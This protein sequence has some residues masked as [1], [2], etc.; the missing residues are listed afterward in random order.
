[1]TP[2]ELALSDF[3]YF[4]SRYPLALNQWA[5][6]Q[7]WADKIQAAY[8]NP[9]IE[10]ILILAPADHGKTSRLSIP[11][12]L[13]LLAR[14]PSHRIIVASGRDE[15]AEQIA[16]AAARHIENNI[17][18]QEDFDLR[19]SRAKWTDAM[20][21]VQRPN[22][23]DKDASILSVGTNSEIQSQRGDTLLCD[24]ICTKKNSKTPDMRAELKS[25][26]NTDLTSRL[27]MPGGKI[28]VLGHRVHKYDLYSEL[29]TRDNWIVIED[30]AIVSD[31]EQKVLAP[32][33]WTYPKLC[34]RRT[35]DPVGFALFYQQ[36]PVDDGI[37]VTRRNCEEIRD[38]SRPLYHQIPEE[39]R[40]K[41][42]K[43]V[44]AVDPAFSVNRWSKY[45][46][47]SVWGYYRNA[48]N[49]VARDLLY[50]FRDRTS[51]EQLEQILTAKIL[52]TQ[53][54]IIAYEKN[55]GQVLLGPMIRRALPQYASR[56][57]GAF[58]ESK[59]GSL[60]VELGKLFETVRKGPSYI[61]VP[62]GNEDARH[63]SEAFF[64]E[65]TNYPGHPFTD[66]I[67]SWYIAEKQ[68]GAL[69]ADERKGY[70]KGQGVVRDVS[71]AVRRGQR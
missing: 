18:L 26:F 4:A 57:E 53:P 19:P 45:T 3:A 2:K 62:Y 66:S 38:M 32:E 11:L 46:V 5:C 13:W 6:Q 25:W 8:E 65:L 23:E 55:L 24:D 27:D 17:R 48:A 70:A 71:S 41:Y 50:F 10:G 40:R 49:E 34:E 7:R 39:V 54:D 21:I 51:A 29:R 44:F 61:T 60:E 20:Y 12:I 36:Q 1:M 63:A 59:K 22:I 9:E 30:R 14:N 68:S 37:Y 47:I 33:K 56:V 16:G 15:Y 43:I 42:Q 52:A 69:F 58:T 28:I 64:E 67:M 35:N 31:A